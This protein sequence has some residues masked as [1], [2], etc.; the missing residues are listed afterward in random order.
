HKCVGVRRLAR[1]L[2]EG[3]E[4]VGALAVGGGLQV[5]PPQAG[6]DDHLD[7]VA[8]RSLDVVPDAATLDV[9]DGVGFGASPAA[10]AVDATDG[11]DAVVGVEA[12]A[13]VDAVDA[14]A[15]RRV[16]GH[17]GLL[18]GWCRGS[19]WRRLVVPADPVVTFG[20]PC[21][22]SGRGPVRAPS[23]FWGRRSA[24]SSDSTPVRAV[25]LP[26]QLSAVSSLK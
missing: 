2:G 19:R 21:D 9:G 13:L 8:R 22:W 24:A 6:G 23:P 5:L 7:A 26:R 17:L 16:L 1:A 12:V 20:P 18:S 14:P 25:A 3:Q 10:A 4:I 11:F 15:D